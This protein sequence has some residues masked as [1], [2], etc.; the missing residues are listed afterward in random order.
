MTVLPP[1]PAVTSIQPIAIKLISAAVIAKLERLIRRHREGRFYETFPRLLAEPF[2]DLA[3]MAL[4]T[5]SLA[6]TMLWP[7]RNF[8]RR[9]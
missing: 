5:T 1:T 8:C 4:A 7:L 2:S 6:V 3:Y 9:P